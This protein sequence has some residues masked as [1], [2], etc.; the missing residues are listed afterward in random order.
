LQHRNWPRKKSQIP[1]CEKETREKA[2]CGLRSINTTTGTDCT[3]VS[4]AREDQGSCFYIEEE[5]GDGAGRGEEYGYGYGLTCSI[6]FRI[7]LAIAAAVYVF[8]VCISFIPS[9]GLHKIDRAQ[10]H[11]P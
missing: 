6:R 3:A 11:N 7:G 2:G 8:V 1:A 10:I 5:N 9:I 4:R